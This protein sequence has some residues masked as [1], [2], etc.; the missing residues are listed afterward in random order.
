MFKTIVI[1]YLS[2]GFIFYLYLKN[3][4]D[5]IGMDNIIRMFDEDHPGRKI[6][7]NDNTSQFIFFIISL[8]VWPLFFINNNNE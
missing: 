3:A 6:D 5:T 4:M 1:I 7:L 8:L 2:I